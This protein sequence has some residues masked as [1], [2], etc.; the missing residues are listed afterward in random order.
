MSEQTNTLIAALAEIERHVS[1]AGWDQPARLFA[2]VRTDVLIQQEPSL[3][4]HLTAGSPDSLSSIEQEDFV[5]GD[6]LFATLSR[7]QWPATVAGCALALERSFLPPA[8]DS[9]IP[10]DPAAAEEFVHHHPQRQDAR[11]VVGALRDGT[12][13]GLGRLLSHPDELLGG[14]DFVP[15]LATALLGTLR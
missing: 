1:R 6:S 5:L 11:V 4:A 3:A 9:Q 7:I 8:L 12:Q 15:G 14:D 2:L 10:S 13:H